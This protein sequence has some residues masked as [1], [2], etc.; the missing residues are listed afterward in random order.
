MESDKGVLLS[1]LF[2]NKS[3]NSKST[4]AL[5]RTALGCLGYLVRKLKIEILEDPVVATQVSFSKRHS[6]QVC[7]VTSGVCGHRGSASTVCLRSICALEGIPMCKWTKSS[8]NF[9]CVLRAGRL[10]QDRSDSS[11]LAEAGGVGE[12]W[13][14]WKSEQC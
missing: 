3:I 6:V 5:V 12:A 14:A 9:S 8:C 13:V 4:S 10:P 7:C 1:C 2:C 11:S